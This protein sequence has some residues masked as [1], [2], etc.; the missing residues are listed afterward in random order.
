LKNRN[1]KIK[2]TASGKKTNICGLLNDKKQV[3]RF[4]G[5]VVSLTDRE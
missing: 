5:F 4:R 3:M 1:N 2:Y